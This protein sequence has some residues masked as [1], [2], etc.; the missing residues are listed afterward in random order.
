M[1]SKGGGT[2][3][4]LATTILAIAVLAVFATTVAAQQ[5]VEYKVTV[6]ADVVKGSPNDHFVTFSGPVHIPEVTL[7]AGTYIFSIVAPSVVQVTN[8]DRSRFY[9][10]FF[11]APTW[12]AEADDQYDLRF[13]ANESAPNRVTKWFLPNR[14]LGFEFLYP[15]EVSGR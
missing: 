3:K 2:M 15:A 10:T 11:T 13:A 8:T 6:T 12:R 4:R 5:P 9:A 1:Q 14:E 7:P